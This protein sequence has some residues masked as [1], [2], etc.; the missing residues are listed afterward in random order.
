M[1]YFEVLHGYKRFCCIRYFPVC[2]PPSI[3]LSRYL[4]LY[5]FLPS[6]HLYFYHC[7]YL[8]LF[9]FCASMFL[10]LFS[11]SQSL[12]LYF[13]ISIP[14]SASICIYLTVYICTFLRLHFHVCVSHFL[15]VAFLQIFGCLETK[16]RDS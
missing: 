6:S 3:Y 15:S 16:W 7:L 9:Y 4:S 2:L 14:I 1:L 12:Y 13:C 5:L 8:C 10:F 11:L